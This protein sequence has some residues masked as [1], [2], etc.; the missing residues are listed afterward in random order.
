MMDRPQIVWFK[1][2][3]R[4]HDHAPLYRATQSGAPVVP[5]YIV[6]PELWAQPTSSSRHWHFINDCLTELSLTLEK[7]GQPL[8]IRVGDAATVLRTLASETRATTIWAHEETGD[9]WTYNR[10]LLVHQMCRDQGLT[11]VECPANGVIRRLRNR[12]DWSVLRNQ[13]MAEPVIPKPTRL[14]GVSGCLSHPLPAKDDP[15]FGDLLPPEQRGGRCAAVSDLRSFFDHRAKGY[16]R[17][18]SSPLMSERSCSRLSAHL[19]WGSLSVREVA[20]ALKRRQSLRSPLEK[21]R[22]GRNL[23]AFGSRLAWRCHFVQKLEDQPEI[24]T[25]CMHPAFEG[26]REGDHDEARFMAWAS[27]QTGFPIIDAAMR[28]LIAT[29][30][31]TF[32]MRAML[33]SFASYQLWLDWRKTAPYLA[34]LF[35]DYEPGIHYS[36]FQMQ[37][38][39]TGINALRI[40]NPIKQSHDQDPTGVFIRRWVPELRHMSDAQIHAPWLGRETLFDEAAAPDYP[41][42]IVDQDVAVQDAKQRISVVR[43]GPGFRTLSKTVLERHGSRK[44]SRPKSDRSKSAPQLPLFDR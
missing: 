34:Q 41:A 25:R 24:E 20:Q 44:R 21:A 23:S 32:R 36:Q 37:S 4:A 6:E 19:A 17:N 27:G 40:Y 33:V 8:I 11:F 39:V 15:M 28:S 9:L 1:R 7:L 29:G 42:P 35:T 38:G 10:D 3:L 18:I 30:W 14:R 22:F 5:V 16:L 26:L 12:D 43:A 13:R 31:I 2:D